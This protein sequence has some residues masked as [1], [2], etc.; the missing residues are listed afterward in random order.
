MKVLRELK[1]E[2][3]ISE[4]DAPFTMYI[5]QLQTNKGPSQCATV[6]DST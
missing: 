5:T 2:D 4:N 6:I 1:R 3:E